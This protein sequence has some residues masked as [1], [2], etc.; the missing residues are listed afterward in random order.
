M[1]LKDIPF[2]GTKKG[3]TTLTNNSI[4]L[5]TFAPWQESH[6][7]LDTSTSFLGKAPL[8]GNP[9]LSHHITDSVLRWWREREIQIV[10]DLY[11]NYTFANFQQLNEKFNLPKDSFFKFLQIRDWVKGKSKET[12]PYIPKETPLESHL[13]NKLHGSSKGIKSSIYGII[14]GKLPVYDKTSMK[15]KWEKDLACV[16]EEAD[17]RHLLE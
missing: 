7:P 8:W 17:W 6:S 12:F 16:Y 4:I 2:I 9:N 5:N 1:A 3:L 10:A 13:C 11:I 15:G 14:N